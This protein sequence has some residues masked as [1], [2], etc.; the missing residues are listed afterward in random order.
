MENKLTVKEALEKGFEHW[1]YEGREFQSLNDLED[2]SPDDFK[3]QNNLL[4]FSKEYTT[5]TCE[6]NIKDF[7]ADHIQEQ[8]W[9]ETTDDTNDVRDAIMDLDLSDIADRIN[10]ALESKKYYTL[11]DIEL[12]P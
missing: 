10:K 9:S 11:T 2:I 1:G 7:L 12:I 4:L 3:S 8:W 6:E 5:P